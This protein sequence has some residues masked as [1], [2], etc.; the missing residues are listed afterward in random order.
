M[1]RLYRLLPAL[2]LLL[3]LL[4][5]PARAQDSLWKTYTDA[6]TKAYQEERYPEAE[7]RFKL[8]LEEAEGLGAGNP[9]AALS[10]CKLAL[11]SLKQDRRDEAKQYSARAL[12]I[13]GK[14]RGAEP[15]EVATEL[16]ELAKTFNG[17]AEYAEA[18]PLLKLALAI[19]LDVL[20]RENPLVA[21]T[22]FFL[23][24]T[25][26]YQKKYAAADANYEE[27]LA[28]LERAHTLTRQDDMIFLLRQLADSYKNEGK[29]EEA[30]KSYSR[31]LKLR[32]E[33][34]GPEHVT[35]VE[36][37]YELARLYSAERKYAEAE[38]ALLSGRELTEKIYGPNE[39]STALKWARASSLAA[40]ADAYSADDN[41]ARAEAL[42]LDALAVLDKIPGDVAGFRFNTL[43]GLAR[44]YEQ[45][46]DY[47][48]AELRVRECLKII[49]TAVGTEHPLF[50]TY[51]NYQGVLLMDQDK[52]AEAEQAFKRAL[53]IQ[54]RKPAEH[55]QLVNSINNLAKVY[56]YQGKYD[57]A[58]PLYQK[59]LETYKK[60]PNASPTGLAWYT[61]NYALLLY[62]RGKKAEAE[63]LFQSALAIFAKEDDDGDAAYSLYELAE[64]YR[65]QKKYDEAE[66]LYKDALARMER[67]AKPD[68]GRYVAA[69][70]KYA[71]LLRQTNREAEAS[72]AE[73]RAREVR[74][75]RARRP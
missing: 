25:Y 28:S 60:S 75:G 54:E 13:W 26:H 45:Q 38:R 43:S 46:G 34:N 49:E 70:E 22:Y 8:A 55:P 58:E 21:L 31:A 32:E 14:N 27:G 72:S 69:L 40:L 52:Y 7:R 64:L 16:V 51:L 36:M 48:T 15:A 62:A 18:E 23:A 50:A 33:S 67:A 61:K 9:R 57:E 56:Y 6:G 4:H 19:R 3:L 29:Y 53:G 73:A 39:P 5:A 47:A 71:A 59:L 42:Y 68:R 41:Y 24:Q 2:F 66:P 74:S 1:R 17:K 37:W 44:A 35:A 12:A 30:E 63:Q 10:Y 20:Q 11:V 65:R